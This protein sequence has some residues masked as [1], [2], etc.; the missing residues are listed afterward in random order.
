MCGRK[1]RI[2]L[3]GIV[4]GLFLSSLLA[5]PCFSAALWSAFRSGNTEQE[6]IVM[7]EMPTAEELSQSNTS[8]T[9][10]AEEYR[11][12]ST[13]SEKP[14]NQQTTME[15]SN[16]NPGISNAI[17]TIQN[18][19]WL[20]AENKAILENTLIQ[21][22]NDLAA[23]KKSSDSKDAEITELKKALADAE[24]STGTKAYMMMEGIIGFDQIIPSYGAGLT[25]G[26]RLGN[27]MMMELGADYT[28]GSFAKGMIVN[29]FSLD[30][31]EFRVGMGWMF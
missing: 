20:S 21:A 5:S 1:S 9:G 25:L 17:Q 29:D 19:F 26:M 30:N 7:I 27:H 23:L 2:G 24:E 8:G 13:S 22:Q 14:Q 3:R 31:F 16:P 4:I 10:Q 6:P 11:T 18:G 28:I 12:L 15:A